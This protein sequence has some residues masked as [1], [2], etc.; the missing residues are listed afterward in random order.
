MRHLNFDQGGFGGGGQRQPGSRPLKKKKWFSFLHFRGNKEIGLPLQE[1][2]VVINHCFQLSPVSVEF[3]CQ[4][5]QACSQVD[6]K[7]ADDN[8]SLNEPNQQLN[9]NFC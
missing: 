6:R 5:A 9:Q 2:V 7:V 3:L 8:L 4:H 1:L